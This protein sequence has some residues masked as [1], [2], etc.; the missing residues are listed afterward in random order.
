MIVKDAAIMESVTK[1]AEHYTA[2]I[3][4]RFIRPFLSGVLSETEMSN[5]IAEMTERPDSYSL[6]GYHLDELYVQI[7]AMAR[8]VYQVRTEILPNLRLM[9]NTSGS[10]NNS[11]RIFRDMAINNFG[12]NL[13]MLADYVNE[14]Y[15]QTVNYDRINSPSGKTLYKQIQGLSEIGRY[16]IGN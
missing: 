12:A 2:N 1:I 16:L 15:M 4:S 9:A 8:F 7:L 14:L 10:S 5:R 13:Q 11:D 3:A 6:Q